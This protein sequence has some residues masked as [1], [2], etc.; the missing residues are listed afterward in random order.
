MLSS[1]SISNFTTVDQLH[2]EIEQG[3]V[4]VTGETGAGK[5]VMLDAISLAMGG[6][7]RGDVHR[8]NSKPS[9]LSV[10]FDLN[11]ELCD[12]LTAQA[13]DFIAGEDLILRRRI[14][15]DGR[16]RAFI[17]DSP[18]NINLLKELAPLLVEQH[19]QHSQHALLD[20]KTHRELLDN[21]AG[22][23]K[24]VDALNKIASTANVLQKKL[25]KLSEEKQ[26][27]SAQQQLLSYQL[28]E[29]V[30]LA[31]AQN[32]AEALETELKRLSQTDNLREVLS[33]AKAACLDEENNNESL[34]SLKSSLSELRKLSDSQPTLVNVVSL[35]DS[36]LIQLQEAGEEIDTALGN[37]TDDPARLNAIESRL[38]KLY[39]IARKH[40]VGSNDL[41]KLQ[42]DIKEQLNAINNADA[43]A[44]AITEN[45]EA[46]HQDFHKLAKKI[47]KQRKTQARKLEAAVNKKLA[48]LS[49]KH[50]EF[51]IS[52]LENDFAELE[53]PSDNNKPALPMG[54]TDRVEFLISTIPGKPPLALNSVASGGELSRISLAIKVVAAASKGAGTLIFDEVDVGIGG[55]VAEVVGELIRELSKHRQVLCVTHLAQVASKANHHCLVSKSIGKKN[56]TTTLRLLDSKARKQELARMM[57]GVDITEASLAQAEELLAPS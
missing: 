37:V 23:G 22:L 21:F 44:D 15:T 32:E 48:Q 6:R 29:L 46:L 4:A 38:D 56:V 30:E 20:K 53:Q 39:T 11:S 7:I 1:L 13:I 47:S 49:M 41:F 57:S 17:N 27:L 28:E 40:Q 12:W 8:D 54:G 31:P 50:C 26:A 35:L 45:I 55:G 2:L 36:A 5:S 3:F 18:V 19:S 42:N 33:I 9:E 52:I 24:D 16:S 25:R 34:R 14:N 51:K 43:D 10:S